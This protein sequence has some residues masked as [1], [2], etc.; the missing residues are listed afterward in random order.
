VSREI[1]T[2]KRIGYWHTPESI[3]SS[4]IFSSEMFWEKYDAGDFKK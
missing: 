1:T 4:C 3:Y 2:L